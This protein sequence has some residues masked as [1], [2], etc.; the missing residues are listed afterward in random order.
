MKYLEKEF[1]DNEL[2]LHLE[3]T[4]FTIFGSDEETT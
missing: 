2:I 1:S 4:M 3:D